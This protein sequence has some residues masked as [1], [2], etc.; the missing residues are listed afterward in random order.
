MTRSSTIVALALPLLLACEGQPSGTAPAGSGAPATGTAKPAATGAA[1]TTGAA[2]ATG[3]SAAG[4]A[5]A[6]PATALTAKALEAYTI[7]V[8]PGG[9]VDKASDDKASLETPDYK[10]ML[11]IGKNQVADVKKLLEKA[12][13]FKAIVD[14]PDGMLAEYEEKGTKQYLMT[15]YVTVGDATVVCENALTKPAKTEAKAKEAWDV[16][17][18]VK[19]K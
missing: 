4:A 7:G 11:S 10:L 8:P 14:Q 9:K 12:P 16:C 5:A 15:R 13:G 18:T 3:G 6:F 19:K 1:A 2:A 17:G